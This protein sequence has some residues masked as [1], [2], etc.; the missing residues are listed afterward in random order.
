VL[1]NFVKRSI[2]ALVLG[3]AAL[4]FFLVPIGPKTAFQHSVA[5]FSSPPARQAGASFAEAGRRATQ[6]AH[7][8]IRKFLAA[9]KPP[10]SD[11]PQP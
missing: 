5:I 6:S 7:N 10:R 2:N 3:L 11:E 4:T 1:G 8:E 9:Q